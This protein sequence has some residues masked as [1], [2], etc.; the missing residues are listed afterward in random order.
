MRSMC[1]RGAS[2]ERVGDKFGSTAGTVRKHL[3]ILGVVMR[4][5]HGRGA[6]PKAQQAHR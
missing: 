2:R 3:I 5:T 1:D 4:D 6:L